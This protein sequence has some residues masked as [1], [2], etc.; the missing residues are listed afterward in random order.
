MRRLVYARGVRALAPTLAL[1]LAACASAAPRPPPPPASPPAPPPVAKPSSSATPAPPAVEQ[2]F[3]EA[4]TASAFADPERVAKLRSAFAAIDAIGAAELARQKLPSL[5][6]GVV[7][8]G[9]LAYAK[10]FGYADLEKKT[11]VD[12]DTVYRIASITKSFTG[13]ALLALRDDGVLSL[14]D[15]L[16]R[17]L[18][19]ARG[20][21]Y[22]TRDAAPITL[23]QLLTHTSGLPRMGGFDALHAPSEQDIARSLAGFALARPPGSAYS[24]SNLGFSLLGIVAGR[25]AHAR[26]RDLVRTRLLA[27]LGMT[28][29]AFDPADLPPGRLATPYEKGDDGGAKPV[30]LWRLGAGEASGGIYS[31]TRDLGRWVAFQLAAYPPRSG[32]DAGPVKRSTVREAH[33][34]GVSSDLGVRL[35]PA[36]KKGEWAVDAWADSYGFG[37]ITETTCDFDPVVLH[38]GGIDGF[39]SEIRFLPKHGVGVVALANLADSAPGVV[40]HKAL[41]ALVKTGGLKPRTPV[42]APAFAPAVERLLAVITAWDEQAYA[43]MLTKGRPAYPKEREELAGYRERHGACKGW[44]PIEI[45]DPTRARLALECERGSL[46]MSVRIGPDGLIAGFDGRS[47]DVPIPKDERAVADAIVRLIA[48]WDEGLYKRHLAA[49]FKDKGEVRDFYDHVRERHGTCAVKSAAHGAFDRTILLA[50]ERGGD[51]N[52]TLKLDAKDPSVV[53]GYALRPARP[54]GTCPVR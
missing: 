8:D 16:T 19:E 29:T 39:S 33:S 21:V 5:A 15:P 41:A 24:Y 10:G 31:S 6:I 32:P 49:A 13:T 51:V 46:D 40:A 26:Y 27:P 17:F 36:A 1:V 54:G 23:R 12:A 48:K 45:E 30:E 44:K 28:S 35:E 14:D 25:A 11:P 3:A 47:R 2:A 7:I 38:N 34:T 4:E 9:E 20:L 37:W 22:P 53:K 43:A 52:L 42:L 50:C 18:P